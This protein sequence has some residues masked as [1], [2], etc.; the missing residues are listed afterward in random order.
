MLAQN[1]QKN[2]C[3]GFSL[4]SVDHGNAEYSPTISDAPRPCQEA[5]AVNQ[6]GGCACLVVRG[7]GGEDAAPIAP[8]PRLEEPLRIRV[9]P[10]LLFP[11]AR[12]VRKGRPIELA[13]LLNK[14]AF[15]RKLRKRRVRQRV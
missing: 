11:A 6:A 9:P 14:V 10:E 4:A 13:L 2:A 15:L 12:A 8:G 1:A 7:L 3:Q 5:A